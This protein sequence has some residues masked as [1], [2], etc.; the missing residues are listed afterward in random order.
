M[1]SSLTFDKFTFNFFEASVIP[2]KSVLPLNENFSLYA[3]KDRYYGPLFFH[4][5]SFLLVP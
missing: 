2:Q 5:V 3:V 4:M 1:T